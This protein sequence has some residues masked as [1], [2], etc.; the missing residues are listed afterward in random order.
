MWSVLAA[1]LLILFAGY[2]GIHTE[3]KTKRNKVL[4]V[5]LGVLVI[6]WMYLEL[7]SPIT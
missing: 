7:I 6:A 4:K 1:L 2:I 3:H 5:L